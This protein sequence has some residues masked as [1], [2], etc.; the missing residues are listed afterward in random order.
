MRRHIVSSGSVRHRHK[1]AVLSGGATIRCGNIGVGVVSAPKRTSF[2]KR[3]RHI[4]G[5]I[6]NIM[7]IMSTFRNT[8][9]RAGFILEGTLRLRL[10]IVMYVGGVSHPRTEPSSMVSRILRLFVSLN[11]SSSRL[12]YPFM[13]TSTGTNI[14]ILSL[15]SRGRSVGPLFRAVLSCVP[16][17]RNSPRTPARV[18]V[19][20]VSCGRCINHVKINGMRGNAVTM[21]RSV[22]LMGRRSPSG[23]RHMGVNGLCRFSKL[24]HMRMGRTAVKSVITMSNVASVSVK[25]ALYSP[26]GPRTVPFRG[27]SRPAVSVRFVMGSDPFTKRRNGFIASHR[28]HSHLF[29]RLGASID[30]HMRRARGT[31]DFGMSNHNRLRL[32]ILVR[33]VHHRKCR[34]TMDGTRILCRASRGN[35]GLRP[36]RLTCVSI[37]S[38]FAKIIVRGLNREGNRLHGVAPSGNK[39]AHLRFLVPTHKLVKCHKRFVASAGKGNVVGADFRKCTPCGKSVRCHGRKSLVTFRANRSMA[40]NLCDT[41]RHNALF[42]KTNRG[43]CSNVIVKRGNG[44]RSVRLGM[45]GA[46]RLAGAHSSDTSRTLHLAPPHILD[47]RRTLSFVSASRLLRMAPR[48]LHV[49]GGVLSSEVEGHDAVGGWCSYLGLVLTSWGD[50]RWLSSGFGVILGF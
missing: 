22:I 1:V 8:V 12:R 9:P 17:P 27:V 49:H 28:L 44:T 40:C 36:V 34:F 39:C 25:S 42:V 23:R 18:L 47:L 4:L 20:A 32:S 14:T 15:S 31:S 10:P 37:P 11:T 13:C 45:Y 24:G 30:L 5:V 46:G 38:R 21:G 41:R 3:I 50:V 33:G 26:R 16:T 43:M 29:H 35:G 7:L 6:G 48:G 2:N 19:D